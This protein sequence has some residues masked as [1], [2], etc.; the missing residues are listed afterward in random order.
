MIDQ[1]LP[2]IILDLDNGNLD[3]KTPEELRQMFKSIGINLRYIQKVASLSQTQHIKELA[4]TELLARKIKNIIIDGSDYSAT[5]DAGIFD[6][7]HINMLVQRLSQLLNIELG[8]F[9]GINL[10]NPS[11]FENIVMPE[12]IVKS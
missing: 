11:P 3:V 6:K 12:V 10:K 9:D 5:I 1:L 8:L 2:N 4:I 7:I